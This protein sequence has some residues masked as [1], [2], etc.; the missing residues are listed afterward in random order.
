[1][2]KVIV[3]DDSLVIRN[4]L[5]DIIDSMDKFKVIDT[6]QDAY[7]AR[8]KIKKLKPDLV[9][10]DIQM[11]KMDGVKFLKNLMKLHPMPAIVISSID[12]EKEAIALGARGFVKKTQDISSIE[13]KDLVIEQIN[14]IIYAI[15]RYNSIKDRK[16][17][18]SIE[19]IKNFVERRVHP[20]DVLKSNPNRG[21]SKKIIGIGASTGGIDALVRVFSRLSG[22]LAP[23]LIVQHIPHTFSNSFAQRLDKASAIVVK[24]A[25]D[26][27][28]LKSSHAYLSPGNR[29]LTVVEESGSL[30]VRLLDGEK[31]S[32]HKPSVDILMRSIN[33]TAGSSSM[34]I[35]L[36]GMG[37][38]GAIGMRELFLNGASTIAQSESSCVVYGMPKQ[39][40]DSNS[41]RKVL[42][43][44][45]IAKEMI[46][47][48]N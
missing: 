46:D 7:E 32:R 31:V 16:Q 9:T 17:D 33:N 6:A 45:D 39:V 34:G 43:L 48:S 12:R 3:I 23:I 30:V 36:T 42:D 20:D 27:D 37:D 24:E 5:T 40:V 11:P 26:G 47:F 15:K 19:H 28:I 10:I 18:N 8:E 21:S 35:I 4:L 41:A 1:M 38:D 29:H 13:F 2:F 22:N 14:K 44:E 25:Q